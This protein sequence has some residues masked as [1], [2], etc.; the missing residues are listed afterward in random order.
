MRHTFELQRLK[1]DTFTSW[2]IQLFWLD[3]SLRTSNILIH[4]QIFSEASLDLLAKSHDVEYSALKPDA[5]KLLVETDSISEY[6]S[7]VDETEVRRDS[8]SFAAALLRHG[9]QPIQQSLRNVEKLRLFYTTP[10][11]KYWLSLIC[12]LLYLTLFAFSVGKYQV[13]DCTIRIWPWPCQ[14]I[15]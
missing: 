7:E 2:L 6:G 14:A 10:I 8:K 11:T 9:M 4:K 3:L 13:Y 15:T 5:G 1:L 12:R